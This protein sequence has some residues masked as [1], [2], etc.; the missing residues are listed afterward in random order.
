MAFERFCIK[1]HKF[2]NSLIPSM[3]RSLPGSQHIQYRPQDK[4]CKVIM[5]G[6]KSIDRPGL[7][8]GGPTHNARLWGCTVVSPGL[9][10]FATTC[11]IFLL[12]PNVE[13]SKGGKGDQS[14]IKYSKY[15]AEY[16]CLLTC[17]WDSPHITSLRLN[18]NTFM[19][20]SATAEV[21]ESSNSVV[22]E[23]FARHINAAMA[24]MHMD[25]D[26]EPVSLPHGE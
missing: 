24:A 17:K 13:F 3:G 4:A 22:Q 20:G 6:K 5:W 14:G 18:I 19:F 15:F 1:T 23:D 7:P 21:T 25:L 11:I 2:L 8:S 9:W 10:A 12:S 26:N 16:K